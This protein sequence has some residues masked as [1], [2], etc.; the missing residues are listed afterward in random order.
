MPTLQWQVHA[1]AGA[2]APRAAAGDAGWA[3]VS[4]ASTDTLTIPAPASGDDGSQYRLVA[5]NPAGSITT[6]PAVLTVRY[7]P[8]IVVAPAD[9]SLDLG[10]ALVLEARAAANPALSAAVWQVR[11]GSDGAWSNLPDT[12]TDASGASQLTVTGLRLDDD[13]D[14]YR[15]VF[16][17]SLGTTSTAPVDVSISAPGS[18]RIMVPTSGEKA[19][20]QCAQPVDD[21]VRLGD[22]DNSARTTWRVHSD[23]T[24]RFGGQCLDAGWLPERPNLSVFLTGCSG[25]AS[26]RWI[27]DPATQKPQEI[28]NDDAMLGGRCLDVEG[29]V[30]PDRRLIAF[31][32]HGLRNQLFSFVPR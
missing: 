19:V 18:L 7:A 21:V 12:V 20:L 17:N 2:G 10:D 24:L 5:T 13:G 8:E 6:E 22:C 4:G 1:P 29:G 28:R 14:Q 23:Q 30:G 26:Q 25:A 9:T 32:C 15:A 31:V 16:T 27:L 11:A 3:D